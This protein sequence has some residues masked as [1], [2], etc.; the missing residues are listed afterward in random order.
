MI[1]WM[2]GQASLRYGHAERDR[3]AVSKSTEALFREAYSSSMPRPLGNEPS[4]RNLEV[5]GVDGYY[6]STVCWVGAIMGQPLAL[7]RNCHGTSRNDM[8]IGEGLKFT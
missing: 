8:A 7:G 2:S 1:P 6:Q 5:L 3:N 4:Y